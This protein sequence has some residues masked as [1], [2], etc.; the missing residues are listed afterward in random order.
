MKICFPVH[1]KCMKAKLTDWVKMT[2]YIPVG[3]CTFWWSHF[4]L[5]SRHNNLSL[6]ANW[7]L[8]LNCALI[9]KFLIKKRTFLPSHL[10]LMTLCCKL[11]QLPWDKCSSARGVN[12]VL[13]VFPQKGETV[14]RI[15]E[16]VRPPNLPSTF[17]ASL[18]HP[19]L[20]SPFYPR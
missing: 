6:G 8:M 5:P 12:F 15:R 18:L 1:L 14:K 3:K 4:C 16:E 9:S 2:F 19:C 10:I 7:L 11:S 20:P 17:H 13:L